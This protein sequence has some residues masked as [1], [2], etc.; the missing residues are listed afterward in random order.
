MSS[1]GPETRASDDDR[2]KIAARLRDAHTDGRLSSEEFHDRLDALYTARTYGE[3]EPLVRDIPVVRSRPAEPAAPPTG[4][5]PVPSTRTGGDR[6]IAVLW[7]L[8]AAA[9]S[10]NLVIW[11]LVSIGSGTL[12]YF[13]PMWV[14]GP[15][16]A[17]MIGLELF[18]RV[19]RSGR[20]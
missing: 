14:A 2:E 16:G 20:I 4:P 12:Y 3:L 9:V 10:I 7:A 19:Y 6:A 18:R 5:P 17:G 15:W 8:W 11:V 13:W 1:Y